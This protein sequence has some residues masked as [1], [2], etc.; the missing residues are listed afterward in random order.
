MK[1]EKQI[2]AQEEQLKIGMENA[3]GPEASK[4]S[5]LPKTTGW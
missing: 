3:S 5:K 4:K 1:L 2:S